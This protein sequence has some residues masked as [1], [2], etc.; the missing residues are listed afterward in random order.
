MPARD[1]DVG[2]VDALALVVEAAAAVA[3]VELV[4]LVLTGGSVLQSLND[5][6]ARNAGRSSSSP[7]STL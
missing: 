6:V 1:F 7:V 2:A 3:A 4:L 5:Q